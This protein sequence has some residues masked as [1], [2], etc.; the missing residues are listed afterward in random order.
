MKKANV[1]KELNNLLGSL[2]LLVVVAEEAV[3]QTQFILKSLP[4]EEKKESAK[5]DPRKDL[6]LNGDIP[7]EEEIDK[8][9]DEAKEVF[10]KLF[11][12]SLFGGKG[13]HQ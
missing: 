8:T 7:T 11:K 12:S 4:K 3:E 1:Q 13:C 9:F 5:T 10:K 2:M 6:G